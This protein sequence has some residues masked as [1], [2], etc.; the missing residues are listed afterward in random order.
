MPN[1][2]TLIASS[3]VGAGGAANIAFTSIP[4]TYTDLCVKISSRS[5][6]NVFNWTNIKVQFNSST[7]GYTYINLIGDG[8]TA[9]S[10]N[11]T[12]DG[13]GSTGIM[14]LA[15]SQATNTA[16]TFGNVELYIPNYASSNNKSMSADG[17]SETNATAAGMGLTAGL[18]SNTAAIT[19]ITLI[20]QIGGTAF[21]FLQYSTAY[22]YGIKNS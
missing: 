4:S 5:D 16:N 19:S 18:W 6:R 11:N 1:T 13:E 14:V 7:S 9:S 17:A 2:F 15:Q 20:P 22:L 10:V 8:A 12:N 21:N 3:T